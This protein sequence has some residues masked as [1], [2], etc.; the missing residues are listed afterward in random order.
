MIFQKGSGTCL[1][2]LKDKTSPSV[3]LSRTL[4]LVFIHIVGGDGVKKGYVANGL[5]VTVAL[6]GAVLAA[7]NDAPLILSKKNELSASMEK[8]IDAQQLNRF[9]L[10]GGPDVIHVDDDLAK[11]TV[12]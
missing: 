11:L 8:S 2:P 4:G 6:T 9:V 5:A 1:T 12:K 3:H 7:K 10:L